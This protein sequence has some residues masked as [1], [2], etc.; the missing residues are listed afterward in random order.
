MCQGGPDAFPTDPTEWLDTDGDGTGNNADTD[1]DGDGLDDIVEDTN[2]NGT[3]D[4][5]ETN[6]LD[7]DTDDDFFCSG[8]VTDVA[9]CEA[10]DAFPTDETEWNDNDGDGTGD[11]ADTDDDNDGLADVVADTNGNGTVYDRETNSLD[12]DTQRLY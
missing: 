4:E 5:G 6:P 1:D 12:P 7:P 3:V 10:I 8:T 2:G 11:N 9:V